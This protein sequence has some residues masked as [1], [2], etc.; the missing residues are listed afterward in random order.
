M[1]YFYR[2]S[3]AL[4]SPA[5]DVVGESGTSAQAALTALTAEFEFILAGIALTGSIVNAY[6]LCRPPKGHYS[7]I[8]FIP[9]DPQL[10]SPVSMAELALVFP[11]KVFVDMNRLQ[12]SLSA[13]KRS[14]EALHAKCAAN[15]PVDGNQWFQLSKHWRIAARD[16]RKTHAAIGERES[17]FARDANDTLLHRELRAVE[18]GETPLVDHNGD[19]KIPAAGERR[20]H[21]R[22]RLDQLAYLY[23]GP[24]RRVITIRDVSNTGLGLSGC[25]N[26]EPGANV[27]VETKHGRLLPGVV[28]WSKNGFMGIR[29]REILFNTDALLT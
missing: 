24:E 8:T 22:R 16:A 1:T 12:V 14:T 28:M 13:A 9:P 27:A 21:A 15:V 2:L 20:K 26:L 3:E 19:V 23:A 5:D 11:A 25:L 29:L 10:W 7:I 4:S 6:A 17:P 18:A